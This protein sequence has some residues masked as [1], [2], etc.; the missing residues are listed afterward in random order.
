MENYTTYDVKVIYPEWTGLIDPNGNLKGEFDVHQDGKMWG[1][2]QYEN[3]NT[4][5]SMIWAVWP[6]QDQ[7]VCV[8]TN[9]HGSSIPNTLIYIAEKDIL[10]NVER[11]WWEY[12]W[13]VYDSQKRENWRLIS[14]RVK[15]IFT[16]RS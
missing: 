13:H 2:L 1:P 14:Q 9:T 12:E 5:L 8:L 3:S 7:L 6:V 16:P 15:I 10:D 11:V 4:S